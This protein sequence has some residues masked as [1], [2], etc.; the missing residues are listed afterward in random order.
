MDGNGN[1][2]ESDTFGAIQAV[3]DASNAGVATFVIGIIGSD[4]LAD[5]TLSEMA[6]AGG[7]PRP[8]D[9]SPAYYPVSSSGD[10]IA[11]LNQLVGIARSCRLPLGEPPAGFSR[12]VIDVR[13][14]GTA[15][16]HDPSHASGWDYADTT[17]TSFNLYGPACDALLN[18]TASRISVV[19]RCPPAG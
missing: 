2:N 6:R 16:P 10:L 1:R 9:A 19:Y 18:G 4:P 12:D 13:A 7:Y 3:T 14:D 11:A 5:L 8:G 17:H 15:V